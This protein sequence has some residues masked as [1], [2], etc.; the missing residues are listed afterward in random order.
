MQKDTNVGKSWRGIK[1]SENA[2]CLRK[3][4]GFSLVS[5]FNHHLSP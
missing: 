2:C 1:K 3:C 4:S 5:P